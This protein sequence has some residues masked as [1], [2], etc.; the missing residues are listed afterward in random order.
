MYHKWKYQIDTNRLYDFIYSHEHAAWFCNSISQTSYSNSDSQRATR[1]LK[2]FILKLHTGESQ[3]K[4]T[5]GWT[6][7]QREILGQKLLL[8]LAEDILNYNNININDDKDR[9]IRSLELDGYAYRRNK[10][11]ISEVNVIDTASEEGVLE[12]LYSS[13]L[14][15][16]QDIAFHHLKLSEDHYLSGKWDDSISN[17][18]K[19]LEC[20][21]QQVAKAYSS[22]INGSPLTDA[23]LNKPFRVRE[24]LGNEN[25]LINQELQV[26]V[27]TYSLLSETGGHPYIAENDQARLSRNIVI[28]LSQ[29]VMLRLQVYFEKNTSSNK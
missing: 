28:L 22:R 27:T 3:L 2:E 20:I 5:E 23:V 8:K 1:G 24:Y 21:L 4:A 26:I 18:R 25:F 12:S 9:L 14:L 13:L 16:N 29:F 6:W 19:F 11:W 10:V 7:S 15:E 17:S